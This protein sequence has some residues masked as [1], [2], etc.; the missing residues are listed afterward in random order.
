MDTFTVDWSNENNWL[1]PPPVQIPSVLR[2]AEACGAQGTM[3]VHGW[4]SAPFWHMSCRDGVHW[5]DFAVGCPINA[6]NT[7]PVSFW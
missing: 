5:S 6:F 2:H 3:L 4:E 7:W 1:C